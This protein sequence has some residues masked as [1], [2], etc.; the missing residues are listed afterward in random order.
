MTL[1]VRDMAQQQRLA[2][3]SASVRNKA[4]QAA[5]RGGVAFHHSGMEPEERELVEHLF[6]Q[7]DVR[8]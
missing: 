3:A 2:A 8:V 6:R 7:Q 4:L 5:I 1:F